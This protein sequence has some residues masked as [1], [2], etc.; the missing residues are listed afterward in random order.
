MALECAQSTGV[1]RLTRTL[2]D[3]TDR[4]V[5][6]ASCRELEARIAEER[7]A[8]RKETQSNRQVDHNVRIK[9][10]QQELARHVAAL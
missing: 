6:L 5:A 4:R 8:L 9:V 3:A 10:L 2:E 7:S 1:F